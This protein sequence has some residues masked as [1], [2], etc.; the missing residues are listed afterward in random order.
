[1]NPSPHV[2]SY[3]AA[4][5]TPLAALPPLDD[6]LAADV[7]VVGAGITG[8][9]AALELAARGYT[10]VVLEAERV[11]WGASGRSGGQILAG[12]ACEMAKLERAL[13]RDDARHLW[14]MSLEAVSLVRERIARH[15]IACDWRSGHLTAAIKA[16]HVAELQAWMGE[17]AEVYGYPH[18]R[19]LQGDALG[20]VVR[21]ARYRGGVLD[22]FAGHLH[23]LDYTLGLA[24]A[25]LSAG[26]RV[27]EGSRV[28]ALE[29]GTLPRACTAHG[30][31]RCEHLVLAGNAYLGELVPALRNKIMPVGT[32]IAATEVLGETRLRGLL[33]GH[34][35]VADA[36]FVLDYF[37]PSSD[38][39][40][41]FG[42][43]V[44]YSGLPPPDLAAGLHRR[45]RR[46]FPELGDVRFDY[47][48]GGM[49]D[50]T[51]N[52]APHFGRLDRD[53]V[54]FAQGFSG[55]GMALANLAGRVLGEAI[56]GSAERLDVFQRLRHRDFPGGRW[57][58]M[59]Q[60]VLAMLWFRLRDLL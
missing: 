23:P 2:A 51:V 60:L 22:T 19:W 41:L 32:Y 53:N 10:V 30:S 20:D 54:Y 8:L 26:V 34:A 18:L 21:S 11:G 25:A 47:V 17:L 55:H 59:P 40:L 46:V 6:T 39:R 38:H 7:C 43:R 58:R 4:T 3:Y 24:R 57:L 36:N 31:V 9:S 52:R 56:A 42:G 37:R 49:V 15:A 5:A 44:S 50:I 28:T 14:A 33:P 29:H 35:A 16:R 13:G 45:M 1:M 48:W 12:F 27:F